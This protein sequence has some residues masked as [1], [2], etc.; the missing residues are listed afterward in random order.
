MKF[1][2]FIAHINNEAKPKEES[3]K[4]AVSLS[5][6]QVIGYEWNSDGDIADAI[7]EA[8]QRIAGLAH[9]EKLTHK[10]KRLQRIY[11]ELSGCAER[12]DLNFIPR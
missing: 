5:G 12:Y 11:Y 6:S 8:A 1:D 2:Q 9:R 4:E 10:A 3:L 7:E